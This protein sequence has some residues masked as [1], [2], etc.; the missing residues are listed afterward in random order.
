MGMPRSGI[1]AVGG[2]AAFCVPVE[3]GAIEGDR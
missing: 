3:F 2:G 1:L